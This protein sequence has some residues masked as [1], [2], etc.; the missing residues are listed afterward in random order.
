MNEEYPPFI[1]QNSPASG[2]QRRMVMTSRGLRPAQEDQ[3][4]DTLVTVSPRRY[5]VAATKKD[6]EEVI[7]EEPIHAL[8]WATTVI[9]LMR[10]AT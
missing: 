6:G 3:P 2:E 10:T 1:K 8:T 5:F 4:P 9:S 7:G